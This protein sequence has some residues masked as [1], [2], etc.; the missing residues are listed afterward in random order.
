LIVAVLA[1]SNFLFLIFPYSHE[2]KFPPLAFALEMNKTW[3]S[4]TVIYYAQVNSDESLF[5]YFNPSTV[6]KQLNATAPEVLERELHD[7]YSKG[8]TAWFDVTAIERF[9]ATQEGA[10]WLKK[11]ARTESLRELNDPAYK[12]RYIQIVPAGK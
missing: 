6:W 4:G 2:Q 8:T 7:I 11:H 9:S 12:I 5:R 10:M 1:I 3:P